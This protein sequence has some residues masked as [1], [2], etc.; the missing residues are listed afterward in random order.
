MY[1]SRLLPYTNPT[2]AVWNI[3][4]DELITT[5]L[6]KVASHHDEQQNP[7]VPAVQIELRMFLQ[8]IH[9]LRKMRE[10]DLEP[11]PE[12]TQSFNVG[13]SWNSPVSDVFHVRFWSGMVAQVPARWL[14]P[15][16]HTPYMMQ[17]ASPHGFGCQKLTQKRMCFFF[18]HLR[19]QS[20]VHPEC[21]DRE[22][23]LE[24]SMIW[25]KACSI[26]WLIPLYFIA[27]AFYAYN[28]GPLMSFLNLINHK[29]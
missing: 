13:L 12:G 5:H 6:K 16:A 27:S 3:A 21:P 7:N 28:V 22:H 11:P 29:L 19:T 8:T 26:W 20:Q 14:Q 23:I 18:N 9:G 4:N 2:N 1:K 25:K 24:N 15:L 17:V 10:I